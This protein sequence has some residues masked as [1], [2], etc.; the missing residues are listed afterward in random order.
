MLPLPCTIIILT[1]HS[2]ETLNWLCSIDIPQPNIKI[3]VNKNHA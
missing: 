3:T 2:I 1:T